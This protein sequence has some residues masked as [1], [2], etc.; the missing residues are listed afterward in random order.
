MSS[1]T[2][3][4]TEMLRVVSEAWGELKTVIDAIP[5]AALETPNTIGFWSG[6]DMV[7]HLAGWEEIG[8]RLVR[9]MDERGEFTRLGLNRETVNAFNEEMLVPYRAMSTTAVRESL[10]DTHA[11]LMQL[12]EASQADINAIV[13]DMTRDHYRK[14]VPDLRGIP[15]G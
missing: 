13:I 3:E 1:A 5:D 15:I 7:G 12:A 9:E 10:N 4:R 11:R 14:H 6:R 8:I 2:D